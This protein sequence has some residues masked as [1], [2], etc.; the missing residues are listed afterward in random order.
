MA[1]L[2]LLLLPFLLSSCGV[3]VRGGGSAGSPPS[4]DRVDA[5]PSAEFVAYLSLRAEGKAVPGGHVPYPV[6]R[7]DLDGRKISWP[8]RFKALPATYDLRAQGRVTPVKSQ[9]P[10]GTCW[11]FAA[12][13]SL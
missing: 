4:A 12:C 9:S 7:S 6:D 13:S 3:A 8:V 1:L 11:A 2:L 10:Y 5:P